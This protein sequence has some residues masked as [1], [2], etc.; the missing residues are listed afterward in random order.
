[1][2]VALSHKTLDPITDHACL[3]RL[4][5]FDASQ[6]VAQKIDVSLAQIMELHDGQESQTIRSV[7]CKVPA[8]IGG[9]RSK[10]WRSSPDGQLAR[11]CRYSAEQYSVSAHPRKP[12]PTPTYILSREKTSKAAKASSTSALEWPAGHENPT[13]TLA[14][15]RSSHKRPKLPIERILGIQKAE[16]SQMLTHQIAGCIIALGRPSR[17]AIKAVSRVCP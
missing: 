6:E 11:T 10:A 13:P 4:H 3:L 1:M 12:E 16:K 15:L 17:Y 9:W 2:K 7:P 14:G 8:T 5:S